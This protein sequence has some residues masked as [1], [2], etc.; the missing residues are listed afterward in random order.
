[1][2]KTSISPLPL[3]QLTPPF[4]WRIPLQLKNLTWRTTKNRVSARRSK[5]WKQKKLEDLR[6]EYARLTLLDTALSMYYKEVQENAE[7]VAFHV[8]VILEKYEMKKT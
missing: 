5:Q 4:K 2:H 1:M 8:G 6:A 7:A 3:I